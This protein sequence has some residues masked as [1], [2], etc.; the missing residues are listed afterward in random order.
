MTGERDRGTLDGLVRRASAAA[1][2]DR[3]LPRPARRGPDP[4]VAIT[5]LLVVL[6]FG[7][8]LLA[9][10]ALDPVDLLQSIATGAGVMP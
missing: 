3:P 7:A 8:A 2:P 1:P 10:Y 9:A 6:L 5:V 4:A